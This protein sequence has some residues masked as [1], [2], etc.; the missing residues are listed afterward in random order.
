MTTLQTD[1][2]KSVAPMLNLLHKG[3]RGILCW[4]RIPRSR[5]VPHQHQSL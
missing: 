2:A 4:Q 1:T 3:Y 5:I